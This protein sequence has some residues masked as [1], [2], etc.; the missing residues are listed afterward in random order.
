MTG[1]KLFLKCIYVFLVEIVGESLFRFRLPLV[2][3]GNF[4]V[5][6]MA[7]LAFVFVLSQP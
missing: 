7:S 6:E 4:Y 2:N 1:K 3:Q 5:A